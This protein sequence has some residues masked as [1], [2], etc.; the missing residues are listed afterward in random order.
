MAPL[1]WE[2]SIFYSI[3]KSD[4]L[5]YSYRCNSL[6]SW[7]AT[8]KHF[9]IVL[10]EH[11]AISLKMRPIDWIS[12]ATDKISSIFWIRIVQMNS[13]LFR[14][15]YDFSGIFHLALD[16]N[17]RICGFSWSLCVKSFIFCS[18]GNLKLFVHIRND[19]FFML[20][21]HLPYWSSP[22]PVYCLLLA[23]IPL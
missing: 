6:C 14:S 19:F 17:T 13:Y 23:Q 9:I 1:S 12:D 5:L 16:Y 2:I 22:L 15:S 18:I 11:C 20:Q 7:R 3:I 8:Y 4:S 10:L 21:L